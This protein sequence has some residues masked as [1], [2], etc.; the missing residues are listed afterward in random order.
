MKG[1]ITIM[2][3]LFI[4]LFVIGPIIILIH[5]VGHV[6]FVKLFGGKTCRIVLGSGKKILSLEKIDIYTLCFTGG[7]CFYEDLKM[8][9]KISQISIA[10]GGIIFNIMAFFI[11]ILLLKHINN[12]YLTHF[13]NLNLILAIYN[14]LP[15]TVKNFD[16]D[17]KQLYKTL[18]D[19]V[20]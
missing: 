20:C 5:E 10:L 19:M 1:I 7:I 9:N 16:S 2:I 17:G 18:K 14:M 13:K 6:F 3:E 15:L 11:S 12:L 4:I 8:D